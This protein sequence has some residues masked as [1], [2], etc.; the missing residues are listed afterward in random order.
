MDPEARELALEQKVAQL[1]ERLGRL[2]QAAAA[3]SQHAASATDTGAS[4]TTASATN[5]ATASAASAPNTATAGAASTGNPR[6]AWATHGTPSGS[7]ATPTDALLAHA[8][9][10]APASGEPEWLRATRDRGA[11]APSTHEQAIDAGRRPAAATPAVA[12]R[13]PVP[14]PS[15]FSL[16][17]LEA[18]LTGRALA[19]VGGLAL[20]LGAIFFLSLAFS[21]GWIGNEARVIIGIFAGALALGIGAVFM[22]RGNRLLG[23]VLTPVGLAIISISLVGA[24]R[25][26]GLIPVELGL[27][28]TLASSSAAAAIAIRASS[29]VVAAFGLIAVLAAPPL[30]GAPPD[31]STLAF[32]AVVLIGTTGV[33][34]WR[35][36][37][38]LPTVA[39]LLAAPQV[40]IWIGGDPDPRLGVAGIGL[41]WFIN[42]IAAAG[43]EVR[44][45]RDDLSASSATLML[46][47]A[48][49]LLWAGFTLL[50][51]D[52]VTYRGPFLVL[53][54]IA[55]LAVG[56]AFVRRDGDADLFG[57]L[58]IGTGLAALALAAPIQFGAPAIPI[59]WTAEAAALAW[60]AARR[61]HPYSALV[62]GV[63]FILAGGYLVESFGRI[64]LE[65]TTLASG[66]A[67]SLAFF[68]AGAAAGLW[69]LRDRG[70]RSLAAAYAIV[71]VGLC[72]Y[73]AIEGLPLPITLTA[74]LVVASALPSIFGLLPDDPIPWRT[75]G[76]I[77][78]DLRSITWRPAA[79]LTLNIAI[80]F[81]GI[82]SSMAMIRV[83]GLSLDTVPGG[84]PFLDPSGGAL[85][86][87]LLGLAIVAALQGERHREVIAATGVLVTAWAFGAVLDGVTLVVGWSALFV[88]AFAVWCGLRTIAKEP[89]RVVDRTLGIDWSTDMVLPAAALIVAGLAALHLVF[90][91]LP[92]WRGNHGAL[93][94]VP[95]TDA[96]ATGAL[97]LAAAALVVGA[98]VNGRWNL[99]A[100]IIVAGAIVTYLA[101]FE[102]ASW[103]VVVAWAGLAVHWALLAMWDT[104]GRR[105][106]LVAALVLDSY[107]F[108]LVIDAVAP[109]DRL[110]VGR[111]FVDGAVA[112]QSLA[113]LAAVTVGWVAVAR[114]GRPDR[115]ARWIAAL[116]GVTFV[117]LASVLVVDVMA[118]QTGGSVSIDE[119]RLRGQVALSVLWA[120]LGVIA[121]VFGLR[122]RFPELRQAGLALLG[123][124]T[125]KVFLFDLAALDV[126]YRVISLIALGVLLLAAAGLWQ[127]NQPRRDP[128]AAAPDATR[129]DAPA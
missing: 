125:V 64:G 41:F 74:L 55:H 5:P 12:G 29:P 17:D 44:R 21:R 129:E 61:G 37:P 25:L 16:A 92:F 97:T 73:L 107:A 65:G 8:P 87:Y 128:P 111:A 100:S 70:L 63:L 19:W 1:E 114:F 49:F 31:V 30:M 85:A 28:L 99:R 117:Y 81:A 9:T 110:V 58:T 104:G 11:P 119:L 18:R 84:V 51:G 118:M 67:G 60:I 113:A 50:D 14:P 48:A 91:E 90:I 109:T 78:A 56:L 77:P 15:S 103:A 36:W 22:D 54:S 35:S 89:R 95:F 46:A 93:P 98:L 42:L 52:L 88:A 43:E 108:L 3:A 96:G 106:Y 4:Q 120:V 121:F 122:R 53:I 69:F 47:N 105:L 45:H 115:W 75:D 116:A 34:L 32:V 68:V 82:V 124:A 10:P 76:L 94:A 20:V 33:A 26:Y 39:F 112:L 2:E 7:P 62:A 127:R 123:L 6:T 66:Q 40:A 24:T 79:A 72:A 27:L 102:V 13:A 71:V 38:W 83:Y 126:A 80:L 57:L 101:P 86:I 59:A 23:H